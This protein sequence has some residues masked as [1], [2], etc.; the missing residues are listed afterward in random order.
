VKEVIGSHYFEEKRF[1]RQMVQWLENLFSRFL[2]FNFFSATDFRASTGM[3][4]TNF[5]FRIS[6]TAAAQLYTSRLLLS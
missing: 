6:S 2:I 4:S 3:G 1:N 5:E